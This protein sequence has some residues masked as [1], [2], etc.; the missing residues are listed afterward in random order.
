ML[1]KYQY[2][3]TQKKREKPFKKGFHEFFSG[4]GHQILLFFQ[5]CV[6]FFFFGIILKLIGNKKGSRGPGGMLT[7][8]IFENL[9][10]VVTILPLFNQLL[11]RFFKFF[12]LNLSV[13]S[14]IMHFVCTFSILCA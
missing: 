2:V 1:P 14:N 10:T 9:H 4:R 11:D 3:N 8:E 12:P 13:S 7:Q 6:C 5:V